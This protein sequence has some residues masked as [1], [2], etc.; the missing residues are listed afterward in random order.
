LS[1]ELLEGPTGADPVQRRLA[2]SIK[3]NCQQH[4]SK[5]SN[6]TDTVNGGV[7]ACQMAA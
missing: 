2:C 5:A 1:F 4:N 7:K 6:Q 3:N